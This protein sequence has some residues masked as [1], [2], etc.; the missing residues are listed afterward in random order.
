MLS[1]QKFTPVPVEMSCSVST[2]D[3]ISRIQK[4]NAVKIWNRLW[5]L[6]ARDSM[7]S[8]HKSVRKMF[9]SPAVGASSIPQH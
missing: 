7:I 6:A 9:P 8:S 5:K 2:G 4:R 3:N 1:N